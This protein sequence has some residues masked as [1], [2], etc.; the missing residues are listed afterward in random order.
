L[1]G[2]YSLGT[3]PVYIEDGGS[4]YITYSSGSWS[5][6]TASGRPAFASWRGVVSPS[7]G[8]LIIP[9]WTEQGYSMWRTANGTTWTVGTG[10]NLD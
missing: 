8:G 5:V 1:S 6:Q 10:I 2:P 9:A 4:R 7:T 3:T